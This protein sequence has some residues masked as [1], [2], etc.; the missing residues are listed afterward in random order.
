MACLFLCSFLVMGCGKE[1]G[2]ASGSFS[3]GYSVVPP[4]RERGAPVSL[5]RC[6][7]DAF[8]LSCS[9]LT[10]PP[11]RTL[12]LLPSLPTSHSVRSPWG[13]LCIWGG[14]SEKPLLWAARPLSWALHGRGSCPAW[15]SSVLASLSFQPV[16]AGS[17]IPQIKCFLNGVK[18]PHVVR[19]KV[20]RGGD[21][22]WERSAQLGVPLLS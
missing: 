8:R 1:D 3:L 4:Q 7:T 20:R 16:A 13:S 5:S 22:W 6:V 18:I 17:G 12:G 11:W 10:L 9:V 14:R 21:L 19:L 15:L 2:A